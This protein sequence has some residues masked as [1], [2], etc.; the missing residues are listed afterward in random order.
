MSQTNNLVRK[1]W[2]KMVPRAVPVVL[3]FASFGC[4]GDHYEPDPKSRFPGGETTNTLLSGPNAFKQPVDNLLDE[5]RAAFF[6]GNSFFNSSWVEAPSSTSARD[7]LGPFFNSRNCSGCH[8]DDGRGR[9][10]ESPD[11]PLVSILFRISVGYDEDDLPIGDPVYGGQLQNLALPEL[12]AEGTVSVSYDARVFR[13]PDGS[14]VTLSFP[15]YRPILARG[16]L[17]EAAVLSP[18]VAP[19]MIGLGLL[20]AI[21]ENEILARVDP[22]DEDDDG[23]SGRARIVRGADGERALGRFGWKAEQPTIREQSAGAFLG[24]MGITSSLFPDQNCSA[25]DSVCLAQPSGGDPEVP[26]DILDQVTLYSQTLAVPARRNAGSADVLEG[27]LLFRAVGCASCHVPSHETRTD[28]ELPELSGQ[29]IWPYTDLLLHDLGPDLADADR[30]ELD[31]EWR[32][33]PLW[34]I[35]LISSVNHHTQLLHDGR[36]RGV[37]EAILWHGGEAEAARDEFA[38]LPA[39]ERARLIAF[40]ESL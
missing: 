27:E 33:P 36:A 1:N 16:E 15:Q 11:D 6:S 30:A 8:T 39:D 5:H 3:C 31:R 24:D 28:A 22:H 18:R 13:Y 19:F 21:G 9:A 38:L 25:S 26:D 35:G 23:I 17:D 37:E 32:T 40:V 10:P 29:T 12:E 20:E 7:G 34:G 14:K 2:G 4:Q